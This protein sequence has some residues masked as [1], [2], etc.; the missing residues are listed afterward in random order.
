MNNPSDHFLV[1]EITVDIFKII[2][3]KDF[4]II[5]LYDF[6]HENFMNIFDN[7]FGKF[8]S[9]IYCTKIKVYIL[10]RMP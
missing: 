8:F 2:K 7:F 3:I 1:V 4:Y 9:F 5:N 10:L 6:L